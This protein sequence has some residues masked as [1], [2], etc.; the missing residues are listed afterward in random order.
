M[1][2]KLIV[3]VLNIN[4]L[5]EYHRIGIKGYGFFTW[6]R[7]R[8]A[9]FI[10]KLTSKCRFGTFCPAAYRDQLIGLFHN[11]IVEIVKKTKKVR[12]S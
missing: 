12:L 2:N 6:R 11:T 4:S 7:E 8:I 10:P 9:F 3:Q 5:L 1:L